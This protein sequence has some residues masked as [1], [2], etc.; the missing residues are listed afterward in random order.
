[1]PFW[2]NFFTYKKT[3]QKPKKPLSAQKQPKYEWNEAY[4]A[5]LTYLIQELE[6]Q[7]LWNKKLEL[8]IHYLLKND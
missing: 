3:Y 8:E 5:Y 2:T 7:I 4:Q 1:M 6:F